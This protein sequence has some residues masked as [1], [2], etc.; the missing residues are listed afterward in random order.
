[1]FITNLCIT[2]TSVNLKVLTP[3]PFVIVNFLLVVEL[4]YGVAQ[5]PLIVSAPVYVWSPLTVTAPVTESTSKTVVSLAVSQPFLTENFLATCDNV[6]FNFKISPSSKMLSK[7][8]LN[9]T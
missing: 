3:L 7:D 6:D 2:C 9:S 8:H 5:V 1:M 4:V